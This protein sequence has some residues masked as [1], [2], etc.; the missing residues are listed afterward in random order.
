MFILDTM[1]ISE[2]GKRNVNTNAMQWF[3]GV[4]D[5]SL[6][7]SVITLGEIVRGIERKRTIEPLFSEKLDT[8]AAATRRRFED[9]TLAI[10]MPIALRWG[11]MTIQ[12]KRNDT[13]LLIAATA[14]EHDLTIVTRNVR[15]FGPT[16]VKLFNPYE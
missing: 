16:G 13:D 15:H 12:L 11:A 10:T 1:V 5:S 3:S 8:W 9:K 7:V 4:P 14:L 6:F 2:L